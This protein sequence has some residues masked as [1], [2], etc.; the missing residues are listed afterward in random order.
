MFISVDKAQI[1]STSFGSKTAPAIVGIGGWIGSWELWLDPLS[2]LS[3]H[4]HTVAYDHRGSGATV[5]PL[6]T[7][8]PQHLTDD[9][10]AVMDAYGLPD[11]VLAAE[12]SGAFTALSATLK[13]PERIR[14]LVIVDGNYYSP[15]FTGETP[16]QSH[17]RQNFD[18]AL[19]QFVNAC[20]P[21]PGSEAIRHWG[22]QILQRASV[23]AAIALSRAWAG[24]DLRPQLHRISQPTLVIHGEA[25]VIVPPEAAHTLAQALPNSKLI[26]MPG[27]GHVPTLTRPAEVAQAIKGFFAQ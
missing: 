3:Q 14:G 20:I 8:T 23:E 11:F 6:E 19:T 17:L 2:I 27:V 22:L 15:P 21:E 13:H 25:D 24:T 1:F 5:A 10:F 26:T 12:S 18:Q 4:W 16:F 7:I 9:V